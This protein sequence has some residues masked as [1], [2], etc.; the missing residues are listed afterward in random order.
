MVL[1]QSHRGDR[2]LI[3][4]GALQAQPSP[5]VTPAPTP[6]ALPSRALWFFIEAINSL[7]ATYFFNYI[8]FYMRDHYGFGNRLNLLL[9]VLYGSVYTVSAWNAGRFAQRFGYLFSLRVALAGTGLAMIVAGLL[10]HLL[11]Y[12][13]VT[14]LADCALLGFWAYFICL[15]WPTLQA[16]LS[17]RQP[18]AGMP[19]T[20]G[21]YNIVWAATASIGYL[22]GGA[23]LQTFGG[24]V[25][26]WIAAGL[27]LLGLLLLARLTETRAAALDPMRLAVAAAPIPGHAT[28]NTQHG[29]N[30]P[31]RD[32]PL[33]PS[34]PP[35]SAKA[36]MFLH[37]A[38]LTNPF[39]YIAINGILPVIPKLAERLGLDAAAAGIVCS[40]WFWVRFGAF[41]WFWLWPAWHYRFRWLLAAFVT[42]AVSFT[43]ILLS[44]NLWMLVAAQVAFGLAVGLIY[45]SSLFYSM[46]IGESRGRRGGFHE[47]AI[48]LGTFTGPAVGVV[49]LQTLPSH[50]N[51]GT[52]AISSLLMLGLIPFLLIRRKGFR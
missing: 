17:N 13:R 35:P 42:L 46:D 21:F 3:V 24:E 19:R 18:A 4:D 22:T 8:F 9:S 43:G 39:A 40:V 10:P 38:W 41:I 30:P 28:R 51:A 25:L 33:A 20:A 27:H 50:T 5:S 31:L 29:S 34:T 7:A 12:S 47:A 45:Y 1:P 44:I 52:W 49:A 32:A 6:A 23:L 15:A 11:G 2:N 37:L 48:G 26:F 16:L 36:R 14:M